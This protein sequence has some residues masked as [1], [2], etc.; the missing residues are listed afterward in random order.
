MRLYL[1]LC[2]QKTIR[3]IFIGKNLSLKKKGNFWFFLRFLYQIRL[4]K[5]GFWTNIGKNVF[6]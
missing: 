1:T 4:Q 5:T 3:S 2:S 6:F